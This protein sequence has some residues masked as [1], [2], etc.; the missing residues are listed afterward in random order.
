MRVRDHRKDKSTPVDRL[1]PERAPGSRTIDPKL[2]AQINTQLLPFVR[3]CAAGVPPEARGVKPRIEG[4]III[5]I[6]DGQAQVTEADVDLTD[7]V[8]ASIE[9]TKQCLEQKARGITVPAE[10]E[11][12]LES[13]SITIRYA[14]P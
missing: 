1:L 4:K 7:V 13:Y 3:E 10:N 12:D 14:V 11:A 6:K 2:T 5:A 9:P 8:G